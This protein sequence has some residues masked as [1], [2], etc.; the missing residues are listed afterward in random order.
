VTVRPAVASD[1]PAVRAADEEAFGAEAWT[2]A[3]W[4]QEWAGVP[5]MRHL[6]VAVADGRVVGFGVLSTVA[7]VADL[8]RVGVALGRRRRGLGTALV[9]SLI[10]EARRRGCVR[11][12]LEVEDR[13]EGA[14]ALYDRL[15]FVEIARRDAYYG[16]GRDALVLELGLD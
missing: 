11:M 12:Q 14:V 2:A 7:D 13:N 1:L 6:A 8:H 3:A 9:E 4:Q 5:A 10:A 16:T 15:G